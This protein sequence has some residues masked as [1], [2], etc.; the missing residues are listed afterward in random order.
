MGVTK[1]P[2]LQMNV[3]LHNICRKLKKKYF[4]M[5]WCFDLMKVLSYLKNTIC[6]VNGLFKINTDNY[7]NF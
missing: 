5:S 7:V 2:Y 1:Y 4:A 3:D 6:V